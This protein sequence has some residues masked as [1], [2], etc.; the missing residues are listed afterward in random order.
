MSS[1]SVGSTTEKQITSSVKTKV[2]GEKQVPPLS[3]KGKNKKKKNLFVLNKDQSKY[4]V[5]KEYISYM[6]IK[7]FLKDYKVH[8]TY[9]TVLLS[10]FSVFSYCVINLL[11]MIFEEPLAVKIVK[12]HVLKDK[13]LVDEYEEVIFSKFWTGYINESNASIVI[14][15]KSK[16]HNKKK[17]KIISTLRKQKDKWHIKTLT[18]YNVKKN[19][20]LDTD[21]L[22]T[23][24]ENAKQSAV[25]PMNNT[26]FL[27]GKIKN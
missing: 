9:Y 8:I 5:N 26:S 1:P 19:D 10:L 7:T 18:Y 14:N 13:K 22:K 23:V 27:K 21:D 6:M 12:E 2:D 24:A 16:K 4:L 25:C 15:I 11:L 3:Y 17:G 20:N